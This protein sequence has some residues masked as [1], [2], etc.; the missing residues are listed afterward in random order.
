MDKSGRSKTLVWGNV[1]GNN[2]SPH[3][4]SLLFLQHMKLKFLFRQTQLENSPPL[5]RALG[6]ALL[7]VGEAQG[8]REAP[9]EGAH[10][11]LALVLRSSLR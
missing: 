4:L 9:Q 6:P 8:W 2:L 11:G 1:I 3:S 10:L 5:S 7:S